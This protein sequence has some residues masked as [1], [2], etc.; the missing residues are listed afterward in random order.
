MFVNNDKSN[1]RQKSVK[2]PED[3]NSTENKTKVTCADLLK[4]DYD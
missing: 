3:P 4:F 2:G 1:S